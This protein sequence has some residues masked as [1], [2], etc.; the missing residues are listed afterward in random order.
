M[1][2]FVGIATQRKDP[3][4]LTGPPRFYEDPKKNFPGAPELGQIPSLQSVTDLANGDVSDQNTNLTH[5]E[6]GPGTHAD[7]H[8]LTRN[9]PK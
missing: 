3:G 7:F 8:A 9:R 4:K 2:S 5:R 6:V 1:A